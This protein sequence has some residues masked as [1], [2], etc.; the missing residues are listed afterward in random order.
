[1]HLIGSGG[2]HTAEKFILPN[3][4]RIINVGSNLVRT[5][6]PPSG[7]QVQALLFLEAR[8]E[9]FESNTEE[10]FLISFSRLRAKVDIEIKF[11]V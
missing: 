9:V 10:H 8:K 2:K 7:W 1:M 4:Y 5:T 6:S 3:N 11:S